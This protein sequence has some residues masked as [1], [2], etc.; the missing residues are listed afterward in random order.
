MHAEENR[1]FT[2]ILTAAVILGA[3]ITYFIIS[4]LRHHRKNLALHKQ[5]ILAEVTQI[6]KERARI[7]HDLHDELGPLLSAV[8]MK[9]NSFELTEKEDKIQMEKTNSHIDDVLKRIREISFNLMPNSL[10]RKGIIPALKEFVDYLNTNTSIKFY[11]KFE[12]DLKLTEQNAVNM[13]RIIQEAVHNTIKHAQATGLRIEMHTVKNNVVLSLTDNGI[14]FDYTKESEENIGF[15][16]R[17]LLRRTEIMNGK[18]YID[19]EPGKGTTY[20]FEIPL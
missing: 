16:L 2:A 7:A 12:K 17:S 13:Y 19:S 11:F 6:E 20:T 18:M 3:I 10:L 4:I 8:K 14:G 15:G 1:I 9:I 5:N